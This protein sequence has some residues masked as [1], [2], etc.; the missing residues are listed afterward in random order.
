MSETTVSTP[1]I[2]S[3]Q[4]HEEEQVQRST[5]ELQNI[6]PVKL[7]QPQENGVFNSDE[8][9][10]L[11]N[12]LG[13]LEKPF[14]SGDSS[15][16]LSGESLF[17]FGLNVSGK[18]FEDSWIIDSG[19]TDH[20]THASNFFHT[21]TPCSSTRKISIADGTT[22]TVAGVGDII[23]TPRL[24]LKNVL[25]VPK[26]TTNLVSIQKLTRDLNCHVTFYPSYCDFQDQGSGRRIGR[27]KEKDGL[28]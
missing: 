2:Q 17:S 24:V 4:Q 23:I 5:R 3:S 21:Y 19:A 15:L 6:Q 20:M 1:T 27:A 22:A 10:K 26:L 14:S 16:A 28:Y 13:T 12:L 18:L 25:H 9:E 7:E 8:I 11:R